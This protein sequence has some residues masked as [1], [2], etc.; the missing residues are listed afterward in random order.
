MSANVIIDEVRFRFVC[1]RCQT[2]WCRRYQV[3]R[4]RDHEGTPYE[5]YEQH[6]IA[7]PAPNSG[8]A[9]PSCGGL[10]VNVDTLVDLVPPAAVSRPS[11]R[12]RRRPPM[13]VPRVRRFP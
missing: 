5:L 7:R 1:R 13:L 12:L 4:W 3:R 11:P 2:A 10:R 8:V 9:C 6:G